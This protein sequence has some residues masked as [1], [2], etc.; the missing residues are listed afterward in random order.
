[1]SPTIPTVASVARMAKV[2]ISADGRVPRA[3]LLP[4]LSGW[5][6]TE[7]RD[8]RGR[9]DCRGL[10]GGIALAEAHSDARRKDDH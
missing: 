7:R 1:M 5:R 8:G 10:T 3:Q 6:R 9:I 2:T 4:S